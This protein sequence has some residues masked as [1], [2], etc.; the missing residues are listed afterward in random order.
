MHLRNLARL[1]PLLSVAL[2]TAVLI[3][4]QRLLLVATDPDRAVESMD[5]YELESKAFPAIGESL[6]RSDLAGRLHE[7]RLEVT[8]AELEE[9]VAASFDASD[10]EAKAVEV[11]RD[12][13]SYLRSFPSDP[14]GFHVSV[15]EE[16]PVLARGFHAL[17]EEKL[18]AD[19][20]C[21]LGESVG[22]GWQALRDR[23]GEGVPEEELLAELPDCRPP[24]FLAD[25]LREHLA[26]RMDE[27]A[28]EGPSR[29]R[30]FPGDEVEERRRYG[31]TMKALHRFDSL[32]VSGWTAPFLPAGLL[33]VL[34]VAAVAT[35]PHRILTGVGLG[36]LLSSFVLAMVAAGLTIWAEERVLHRLIL[37]IGLEGGEV[38][39]E[40]RTLW[41]EVV[42]YVLRGFLTV[43]ARETTW[44]AA[45]TG[46]LGT[47]MVVSGLGS[48]ATGQNRRT[49]T[50]GGRR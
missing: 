13:G 6:S 2:A 1:L 10:V 12:L 32:L 37:T 5:L 20:G 9:L 26:D 48:G 11:L 21:G 29:V 3:P 19:P 45:W 8:A 43:T 22:L 36:L 14:G 18:M 28:L 34:L 33:A 23:I 41:M 46:I 30:A 31:R 35:T 17:L 42:A 16:R 50:G 40:E 38:P 7:S 4:T 15:V 49:S 24:G 25:P 39:S 44:A 47:A 27:L